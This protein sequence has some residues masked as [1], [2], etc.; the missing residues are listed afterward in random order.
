MGTMVM[1]IMGIGIGT[2]N[3]GNGA[4]LVKTC[5]YIYIYYIVFLFDTVG[6]LG[7]KVLFFFVRY[8]CNFKSYSLVNL[9]IFTSNLQKT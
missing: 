8:T 3:E 1:G 2:G 6:G 9:M 4:A 5:H 7:S